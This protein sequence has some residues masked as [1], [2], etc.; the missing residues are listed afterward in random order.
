M[1]MEDFFNALSASKTVNVSI[2]GAYDPS[3][4][5]FTAS[6]ATLVSPPADRT[7]QAVPVEPSATPQPA[8]ASAGDLIH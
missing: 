2:E 1:N 5:T 7:V 8:E 6:R 4:G 3:K